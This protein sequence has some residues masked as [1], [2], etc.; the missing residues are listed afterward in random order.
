MDWKIKKKIEYKVI[1]EDVDKFKILGNMFPD[2]STISLFSSSLPTQLREVLSSI[3]YGTGNLPSMFTEYISKSRNKTLSNFALMLLES[4]GLRKS[5][6][7]DFYIPSGGVFTEVGK[8]LNTRY[9]NKWLKLWNTF[10]LTYNP[11]RPYDMEITDNS[12]ERESGSDSTSKTNSDNTLSKDTHGGTT[13]KT[14]INSSNS[15]NNS[16]D[17][18]END[19]TID[20]VQGFNSDTFVPSDKSSNTSKSTVNNESVSSENGDETTTH[21]QTIDRNIN[22]SSVGN[23]TTNYGKNTE[24]SRDIVR[25]GNIGNITQQELIEREREIQMYQILDTIF[26]DLDRVLTRSKYIY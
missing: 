10:Q 5:T 22:S 6:K 25:Q 16:V 19:D 9:Y 21:G 8:I 20:S 13:K 1:T 4:E 7:G 11:I 15:S 3:N 17:E 23:E 14:N 26:N 24:L 18:T 2:L 12:N